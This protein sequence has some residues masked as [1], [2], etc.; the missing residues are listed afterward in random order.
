M[1]D[2]PSL[3]HFDA[4]AGLS[5]SVQTLFGPAP[6]CLAAREAKNIVRR[7]CSR[8]ASASISDSFSME[9]ARNTVGFSALLVSRTSEMV[10]TELALPSQGTSDSRSRLHLPGKRHGAS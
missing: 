8:A 9:V 10:I 7:I 2:F 6:C 4:L 3:R 1:G 5:S